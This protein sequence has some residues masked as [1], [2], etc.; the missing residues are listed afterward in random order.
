MLTNEPVIL[1]NIPDIEDT[2]VMLLIL[3]SLGA[4]VEKVEP[5]VWKIDAAKIIRNDIPSEL[6]KKTPLES[7]YRDITLGSYSFAYLPLITEKRADKK[8]E[9]MAK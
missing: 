7:S 4:S 2:G 9:V 6:K 8:A 3:Q 5:H 1:R